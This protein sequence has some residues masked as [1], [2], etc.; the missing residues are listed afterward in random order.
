MKT[1][2]CFQKLQQI[3]KILDSELTHVEKLVLIKMSMYDDCYITNKWLSVTLGTSVETIKRAITGLKNKKII[4]VKRTVKANTKIQRRQVIGINLEC[5]NINTRKAGIKTQSVMSDPLKKENSL[6]LQ[7]VM[8]DPLKPN[9]TTDEQAQPSQRQPLE[10]Q[11]VM[12]DPLKPTGQDLENGTTKPIT[13]ISNTL[14]TYNNLNNK[15]ISKKTIRYIM[16]TQ[17]QKTQKR[18]DFS[19][20]KSTNTTKKKKRF[21][22]P[23]VEEIR[24]YCI[25]R[26]NTID[27]EYFYDW[28]ASR[29]WF[30]SKGTHMVDWKASVRTWE[31][32]AKK[33]KEEEEK[34]KKEEE[35]RK[36]EEEKRKKKEIVRL[37][38]G[39]AR[40]EYTQSWYDKD[41]EIRRAAVMAATKNDK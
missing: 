31:Y 11:S 3:Q 7:S 2:T 20:N 14:S 28:Y 22:K 10:L 17:T 41:A 19:M 40:R 38:I 15:Y 32:K 8:S 34:R 26:G 12:S 24:Q 25:E 36:K 9:K 29:G 1:R 21:K 16:Y 35:K 13:G 37:P 5:L 39:Q 30:L 33:W 27:P 18:S 6:E 4:T 23:T